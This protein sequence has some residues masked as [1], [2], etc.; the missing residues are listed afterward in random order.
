MKKIR[1]TLKKLLQKVFWWLSVVSYVSNN[2]LK[3]YQS[4]TTG[5][6]QISRWRPR[7]PPNHSNAPNSLIIHPRQ[8][9]WVYNPMFLMSG[10]LNNSFKS[11][12]NNYIIT[13]SKV[14][15]Q[16]GRQMMKISQSPSFLTNHFEAQGNES[17]KPLAS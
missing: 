17:K 11:Q 14:A 12:R 4:L 2:I 7:W 3:V 5:K 8:V 9:I 6:G 13:K 10:N 15:D 1:L 16:Y